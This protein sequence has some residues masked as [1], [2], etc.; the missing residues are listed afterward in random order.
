MRS[1]IAS[2]PASSW[3]CNSLATSPS[4]RSNPL[5]PSGPVHA[6]SWLQSLRTT[7]V[8]QVIPFCFQLNVRVRRPCMKY[9]LR[10]ACRTSRSSAWSRHLNKLGAKSAKKPSPNPFSAGEPCTRLCA[11][12]IAAL[13]IHDSSDF[14]DPMASTRIGN[15]CLTTVS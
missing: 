14:A 4:T 1:P 7:N 11:N 15:A 5:R 12:S 2:P 10:L 3:L 8:K 13:L 6:T 9:E